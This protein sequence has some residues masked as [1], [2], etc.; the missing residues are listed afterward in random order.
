MH[1]DLPEIRASNVMASSELGLPGLSRVI[2][3]M[4]SCPVSRCLDASS[5][6]RDSFRL[7]HVLALTFAFLFIIPACLPD[8][9]YSGALLYCRQGGQ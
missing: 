5:Q 3:I 4:Q 1:S 2:V 7:L 9:R 8:T 6:S